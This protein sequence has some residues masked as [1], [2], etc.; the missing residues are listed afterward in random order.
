MSMPHSQSLAGKHAFVTGGGRGIGAAVAR[1]LLM[2]G[3][4]VTVSGRNADT[5]AKAVGDLCQFGQ[6][7]YVSADIGAPESIMH[8]FS[9]A[10]SHFGPVDILVNNAGH[11]RSAATS[12]P[13]LLS[14]QFVFAKRTKIIGR[15]KRA[16]RRDIQH[17]RA[18]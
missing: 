17:E 2:H 4:R 7:D 14:T 13:Q 6:V 5:L 3:A 18:T 16:C 9:T 8:A 10:R 1:R 11:Q 12:A 15:Q